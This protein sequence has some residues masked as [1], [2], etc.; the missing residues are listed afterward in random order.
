M[1]MLGMPS[2][3][4]ALYGESSR[5]HARMASSRMVTSGSCAYS[6]S[7]CTSSRLTGGASGKNVCRRRSHFSALVDAEPPAGFRSSGMRALDEVD[8]LETYLLAVQ[9]DCS[10][11]ASTHSRQCCRLVFSMRFFWAAR[12]VW[13]ARRRR[14]ESSRVHQRF[15]YGDFFDIGTCCLSAAMIIR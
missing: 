1:A 3:P 10:S 7:S 6:T 15:E 12:R 2:R 13:L 9:T 11:A 14:S 4:V 8:G 5:I